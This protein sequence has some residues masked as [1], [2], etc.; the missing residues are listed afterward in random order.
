[1]SLETI[2]SQLLNLAGTFDLRIVL[3]VFLICLIGEAKLSVPF[4]LEAIWLSVGYQLGRGA[5]SP[6]Q[7]ILLWLAAQAG[8]QIGAVILF[9][10]GRA[11]ASSVKRLLD[12]FSS[13]FLKRLLFR[14][15]GNMNKLSP[16]SSAVGR[17]VGLRIPIS[18]TLGAQHRLKVLCL[19]VLIYSIAWD[20]TYIALGAVFHKTVVEPLYVLLYSLLSVAAVYSISTGVHFLR[21]HVLSKEKEQRRD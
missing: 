14:H 17:L 9:L 20:G 21:R 6:S 13:P 16:L 15:I 19:A 3:A 8:K 5:L 18:L 10:V 7:V 12:S 11:G 4:L 1:M 2:A